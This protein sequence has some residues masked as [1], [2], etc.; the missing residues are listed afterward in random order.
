MRQKRKREK[1]ERKKLH[2]S[3]V[4]IDLPD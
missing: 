1:K 2:G 4:N 3:F